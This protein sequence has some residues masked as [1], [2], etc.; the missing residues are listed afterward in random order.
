MTGNP[1]LPAPSTRDLWAI[2]D[3]NNFFASCERV[4]RPDLRDRPVVVL[5]NNDGCVIARSAEAK[6]L[7]I[8]MGEA[9][10]RVRAFLE[11]ENVAVF[12][13]NYPM[14]GDFSRRVMGVLQSA[15][16]RVEQYSIDEAFLFLTGALETNAPEFCRDLIHRVAEETGIPVSIGVARTRTLAKMASIIAK[17]GRLGAYSLARPDAEV[18][19]VLARFPVDEVWG[20]GRRLGKKLPRWGIVTAS[21][22]RDADPWRVRRL[23]SVTLFRTVLELNDIP[24]INTRGLTPERRTLTYSRSFGEKILELPPLREAVATF[25]AGAVEK[26]RSERLAARVIEVALRT[27]YFAAPQEIFAC[28]GDADLG[29]HSQDTLLFT[30]AALS[31]LERIWR[32]GHPYAKA[33]VTL[34]D[35]RPLARL[36]GSLLTLAPLETER[37]RRALMRAMDSLTA[38]YGRGCVRLAATGQGGD[39]PWRKR[40][41]FLSPRYTADW[42]EARERDWVKIARLTRLPDRARVDAPRLATGP[43]DSDGWEWPGTD[44]EAG[45]GTG[46]APPAVESPGGEDAWP[47]S[48]PEAGSWRAPG[49]ARDAARAPGRDIGADTGE[50]ADGPPREW[51]QDW[52]Q[53]RDPDPWTGLWDDGGPSPPPRARGGGG[54]GDRGATGL[55]QGA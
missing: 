38:R 7:G 31:I 21:D 51:D 36:Q 17:K 23:F 42:P 53:E 28:E 4:F 49:H 16:P 8:A 34:R 47:G 40:Q 11:R 3:C 29:L 5:S 55:P 50:D 54:G 18:R 30:G 26:L 22:L 44:W 10:F 20:V 6:A 43:D 37:R 1:P 2:V 25:T 39:A 27:S 9:Y 33:G 24:C 12:S 45:D 15:C 13:C 35:I 48:G 52:S 41:A 14:Y 46:D 32:P 19:R